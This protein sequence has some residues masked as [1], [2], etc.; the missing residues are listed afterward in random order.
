MTDYLHFGRLIGQ[1]PADVEATLNSK[2][3]QF[4]RN[5]DAEDYLERQDVF[6][7]ASLLQRT[8]MP[9]KALQSAHKPDASCEHEYVDM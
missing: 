5:A 2:A 9:C 7:L 6:C 1:R 8:P 4:E 3:M